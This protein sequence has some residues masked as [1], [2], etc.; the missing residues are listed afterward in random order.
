MK[1]GREK[2]SAFSYPFQFTQ[3]TDSKNSFGRGYLSRPSKKK[4]AL[5]GQPLQYHISK[6]N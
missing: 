3:N 1:K 5:L 4:A 6:K 2:Q